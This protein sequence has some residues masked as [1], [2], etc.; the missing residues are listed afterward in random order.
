MHVASMVKGGG[1]TAKITSKPE[2]TLQEVQQ[3]KPVMDSVI[4]SLENLSI[5]KKPKKKINFNI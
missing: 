1:V 5:N 2:K 4:K 3:D